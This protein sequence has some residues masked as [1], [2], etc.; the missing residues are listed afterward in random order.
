[1]KIKPFITILFFLIVGTKT[2]ATQ[3][4]VTLRTQ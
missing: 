1:M 4:I 3:E 2:F